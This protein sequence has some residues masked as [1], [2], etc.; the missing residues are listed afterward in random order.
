MATIVA[1]VRPAWTADRI[2]F[3]SI[4][5]ALGLATFIGF[6]PTYYLHDYFARPAV[7]PILHVHGLVFT[8][9][10]LT[11]IGQTA[12]IGAGQIRLHRTVGGFAVVLALVVFLLG[13]VVAIERGRNGTPPPG[14]DPAAFLIFPFV[15]IGM[16]AW[17]FSLALLRRNMAQ[18]HK[19]LMLLATLSLCVTP[20]ARLS[21]ML[22][23]PVIP[24]V[25]GML[26]ANLFLIALVAFDL[27]RRGRLHPATMLGGGL[28]LASE[29]LRVLV[30]QS[31]AWQHFAHMLIG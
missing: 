17:L 19:R 21:R 16:F 28:F 2:F 8:A 14:R 4:A 30:S 5:V 23:W 9:W 25:G 20:M 31:A 24:P 11:Y 1:P 22:H 3:G 10:V 18:H 15:S 26:I 7:P 12:L 27:R 13:V 29:P 6:A